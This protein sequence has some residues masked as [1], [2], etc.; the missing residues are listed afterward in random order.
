MNDIVK[1]AVSAPGMLDSE[2]ELWGSVILRQMKGD[3]DV[4]AMITVRKKC[5]QGHP[6]N[7]FR[8]V[9]SSVHRHILDESRCER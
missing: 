9:R 2:S 4:Q 1:E 8:C 6:I 3:S 5:L 7:F